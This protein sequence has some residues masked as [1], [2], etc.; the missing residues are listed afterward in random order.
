MTASAP[1]FSLTLTHKAVIAR[2]VIEMRF[3]KPPNLVF[4]AGQFLQF[5]IPTE[6]GV[7]LRSYSIASPSAESY[8]DLCVKLLPEGRASQFFAKLQHGDVVKAQGPEGHFV[9]KEEHAPHKIFIATGS[10]LAPMAAM[11]PDE[12]TRRVPGGSVQLIFG[13]RSEADIFWA[14]RWEKLAQTDSLF[15]Y[16]I[17]LSRPDQPTGWQGLVGRVTEH[18]PHHHLEA[19]YYLCGSLEMVKDVRKILVDKGVPT[20]QIHFEI[21]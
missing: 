14:E 12:L 16:S 18:V 3:A 6:T 5:H 10:G 2:D 11:I 21:F 7:L 15:T 17:T 20:K 8:I 4:R 19:E 1:L 13:V 9:C